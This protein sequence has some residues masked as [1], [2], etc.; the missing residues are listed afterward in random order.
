MYFLH[1]YFAWFWHFSVF[2]CL[3]WLQALIED[4]YNNKEAVTAKL[5]ES[6]GSTTLEDKLEVQVGTIKTKV[7]LKDN[8]CDLY[9]WGGGERGRL[10]HKDDKLRFLPNVVESLL[11]HNV[12][13]IAC[14][15]SHTIALNS[16]L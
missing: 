8:S 10:G 15:A 9:L 1:L 4:N 3:T 2:L 16:K 5:L 11:G 6:R 13:M 7:L 14:G 12:T